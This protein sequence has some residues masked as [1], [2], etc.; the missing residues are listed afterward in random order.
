MIA[1]YFLSG[2]AVFYVSVAVATVATSRFVV[3]ALGV[4][5]CCARSG[6]AGKERIASPSFFGA[7]KMYGARSSIS[8]RHAR[9]GAR[10]GYRPPPPA[11]CRLPVARAMLPWVVVVRT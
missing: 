10:S 9:S 11:G 5:E 2:V 4:H 8:S 3:P 7:R 6:R 1:L